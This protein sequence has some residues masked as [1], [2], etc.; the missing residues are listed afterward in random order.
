M[1]PIQDACLI[2]FQRFGEPFG[3]V[4]GLFGSIWGLL[5]A[6]GAPPGGFLGAPRALVGACKTPKFD[7]SRFSSIFNGF[8]VDFGSGLERSWLIFRHTM[9]AFSMLVLAAR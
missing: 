7:F 9:V 6:I 8:Y 1:T 2:N 3:G 5:V 4:L